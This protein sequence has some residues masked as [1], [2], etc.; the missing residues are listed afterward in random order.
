MTPRQCPRCGGRITDGTLCTTCLDALTRNLDQLPDLL[1]ELDTQLAR[2]SARG[3]G[4]GSRAAERPLMFDLAAGEVHDMVR[5]VLTGWTRD[6]LE[7]GIRMPATT[8]DRALAEH[9]RWADW[10]N[11]P[12]A[13]EF[14][15]ELDYAYRRG[16][17]LHRHRGTTALPR[18]LRQHQRGRHHLPG[19]RVPAGLPHAELPGVQGHPPDRCPHDLD[20]RA[21]SRPTRHRLSGSR[22]IVAHGGNTS[23]AT[24]CASGRNEADCYR[25]ATTGPGGSS[26]HSANAGRWRSTPST[27][28]RDERHA[29]EGAMTTMSL[30][31]C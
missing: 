3:A 6:L 12:A 16:P 29:D 9:L 10:R 22:G 1:D 14:A 23:P 7:R 18:P 2:L 21:R 5:T 8:D 25:G 30:G 17:A 31:T 28:G 4:N 13:D 24:W 26:T 11:H 20:R 27:E 15:D 19:R